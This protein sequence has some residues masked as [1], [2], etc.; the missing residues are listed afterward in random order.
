MYQD[1]TILCSASKYTR[2][3]YLNPDFNGLPEDTKKR[4]KILCVLYTEDVG[5]LIL[6]YF[7][8][9]GNL[10]IVTQADEDDILF[11]EIGS[12]LKIRQ[13]QNEQKPLFE[14]LET[15]YRTFLTEGG[16]GGTK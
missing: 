13:M 14:E 8:R 10:E 3:Y 9:K 4:L 11:D 6:F 5:G 12:G 15:Y 7:D 1:K 2:K 16:E